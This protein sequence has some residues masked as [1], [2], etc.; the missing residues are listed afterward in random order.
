MAFGLQT[1]DD[2]TRREDLLDVI[3]DVSP[4]ENPL[5]TMLAV[6]TATQTLHEWPED[7]L[8]RPTT[9]SKEVEGAAATYSDLIQPLRR[10][11]ITQIIR[12]TYRVSG[13]QRTVSVAGM[14]DPVEYQADKALKDWKNK[15]EYSILNASIASGNSGVAREMAGIQAVVTSHYTNLNSGTSLSEE[16]FNSM[17]KGVWTDVGNDDVFD[18]VLLPFGL[19]QKLSTFTAGA[20][21][22]VDQR[23]KRLTRPVMIYESDGGVHRIFGHKDIYSSNATPGPMVLGLKEDKYR[24]AYLRRPERTLLSKDGD[25]D[26]GMILGELTIEYLAERSSAR[27]S[28]FAQN[29]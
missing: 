25:R 15:A 9:V 1:Y 27:S 22:Y 24:I 3:N 14:A 10:N 2:S 29:G 28:G 19:R 21:K 23:D 8:S 16:H 6:T 11:N 12:T 7:Y 13:T 20:T 26:N 4:D 17:V 5:M 18:M